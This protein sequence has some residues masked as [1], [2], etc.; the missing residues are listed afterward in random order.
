MNNNI[1]EICINITRRC[2]LHC[3]YCY[4]YDF[5]NQK[6][7]KE[8]MDLSFEQIKQKI[9]L[10]MI[11]GVYLTGGE[12]FMHPEIKKIINY[13]FENSKKINIATNALLLDDDIL[14]FMSNKNITLL[15]SLRD[16]Y[17]ETFQIINKLKDFGIEVI[18]YHLP[19]S[20]SPFVL[21]KLILECSSIKKIKLLYDSKSPKRAPEWFELLY[22]IYRKLRTEIENI[23]I[24]VEIGYLPKKNV[25]ATDERRGAFDRIQVSTEGVYYYCPLLVSHT[26][27][28]MELPPIKCQPD[29]CPILSKN[30]DDEK[31]SSVCCFLVTSLENAIKIG[32][33]GGA[34]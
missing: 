31:F 16:E 1:R 32:K 26:E 21:S 28:T 30:L 11:D 20:T 17:K 22:E 12:P 10:S 25:I 2:N 9:N 18:C 3:T 34:I 5:V 33:Y 4:V 24:I 13:F 6:N 14:H 23:E 8:K 15:V 27:G 7:R 19:S 29:I